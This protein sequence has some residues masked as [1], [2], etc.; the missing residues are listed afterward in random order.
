M[1]PEA[2]T[3]K[4]PRFPAPF[5]GYALKSAD[6][7]QNLQNSGLRLKKFAAKFPAAGNCTDGGRAQKGTLG[8]CGRGQSTIEE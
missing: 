1:F 2:V 8:L 5:P 7:G 3:G 6:F 4:F